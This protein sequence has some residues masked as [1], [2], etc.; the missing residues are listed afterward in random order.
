MHELEM[1]MPSPCRKYKRQDLSWW[2]R[3]IQAIAVH[4]LQGNMLH[5]WDVTAPHYQPP[6]ITSQPPPS[7]RSAANR[8]FIIHLLNHQSA[9]SQPF[10]S[11]LQ[12]HL[13]FFSF[14]SHL[15]TTISHLLARETPWS[16][17]SFV[18]LPGFHESIWE[19]TAS[20]HCGE[21]AISECRGIGQHPVSVEKTR[22]TSR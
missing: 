2:R 10:I 6:L 15:S 20:S 5:R 22:T 4:T 17:F 7:C 12:A 16:A 9:I 8:S 19:K 21:K 3:Q 11:S 13:S 18:R 1:S 14:I